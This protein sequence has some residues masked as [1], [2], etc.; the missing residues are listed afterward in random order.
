MLEVFYVVLPSDSIVTARCI[1]FSWLA[2]RSGQ[3]RALQISRYG[4]AQ[5]LLF[6][7]STPVCP[8]YSPLMNAQSSAVAATNLA[9]DIYA[10]PS[11]Q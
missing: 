4:V 11:A 8:W 2:A 3:D 9:V 1:G 6:C 7:F 10:L 5:L